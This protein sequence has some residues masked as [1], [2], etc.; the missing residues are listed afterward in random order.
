MDFSTPNINGTNTKLEAAMTEEMDTRNLRCYQLE[1]T[2]HL[3]ASSTELCYHDCDFEEKKSIALYIWYMF[4][5]DDMASRD[6]DSFAPF[7]QRFLRRSPQLDPVLTAFADL[8]L[9]MCDQYDTITA[10]SIISATFEFVNST[11]IEPD[12]ERM[13]LVQGVLRFPLFVRDRTGVS[14][15]F[16]LMLF[17]FSKK[18][19]V[20]GYIQALPDMIFWVSLSNDLLSFHKEELAGDTNNYVHIRA[21]MEE[22]APIEVLFEMGQELTLARQTIYK[23]LAGSPTATAAW[24]GFERGYVA[25]H[26]AQKRYKLQ[27]LGL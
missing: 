20:T 18:I 13:P 21:L 22:K 27:D 26:L 9:R 25:S 14:T 3:A 6:V 5:V 2:L 15:S 8:L 7:Q 11:C 1:K 23:A 12:L 16:A 4:Y 17:P 19:L 24:L 10:N